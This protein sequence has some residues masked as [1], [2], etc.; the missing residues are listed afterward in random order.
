[1]THHD[2]LPVSLFL[3]RIVFRDSLG[4]VAHNEGFEE[5]GF[6]TDEDRASSVREPST[7]RTPL[8]SCDCVDGG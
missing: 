4:L 3:F 7:V 2:I 8:R 5:R 6:L 1:M